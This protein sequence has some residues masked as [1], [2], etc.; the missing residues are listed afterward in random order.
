MVRFYYPEKIAPERYDMFLASGWFRSMYMLYKNDLICLDEDLMSVVNIRLRLDDFEMKSRQSKRFRKVESQ[1]RVMVRPAEI[2]PEKQELYALNKS[3][4][5]GYINEDIGPLVQTTELM[6][7]CSMET[8]VYDG[9]RLIACSFFDLGKNAIASL[10]GLFHP[11]YAS[12]SLGI[13]TMLKEIEY[14][15]QQGFKFYYPGYVLHGTDSF[16]YKLSLGRYDFMNAAGHWLDLAHFSP[17]EMPAVKIKLMMHALEEALFFQG[18]RCKLKLYPFFSMAYNS[19]VVDKLLG[20]PMLYTL[21]GSTRTAVFFATWDPK[22]GN[23][24]IGKSEYM[25]AYDYLVS[26]EQSSEYKNS[27]VYLRDVFGKVILLFESEDPGETA[28]WVAEHWNTAP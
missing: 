2:T 12:F 5:K 15:K 18:V 14:A 7:I 19:N 17:M 3:R 8:S 28:M 27:P 26:A 20:H 1:F 16:D 25:P 23:Y 4:F 11:E 24:Q 21:P 6:G 13:F 22:S 10:M 9:E